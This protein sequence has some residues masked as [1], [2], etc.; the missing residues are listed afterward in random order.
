LEET[1]TSSST[2]PGKSRKAA[3][4][5][6][7][8]LYRL[9][10][11]RSI[12]LGGLFVVLL[13][14]GLLTDIELPFRPLWVMLVSVA[15]VNVFIFLRIRRKRPVTEKEFFI[16]LLLDIGFLS[17]ILYL[18]GGSSNPL[19][20]YYLI[21]LIISAAV[22]R[23]R[24][25][26]SIAILTVICYTLLFF[27]SV[28]QALFAHS[29]HGAMP[30]A[31]LVG[32]WV[33]FVFSA[34][35]I[36]WFVVRIAAT[37]REQEVAIARVREEGMRNEQ[38]VSV[39]G[40]AAGTAH[41][42]R[43]PLATMTVLAGEMK[44][45]HPELSEDL[46]LMEQQLGRCDEILRE[47]VSASTDSTARKSAA[48]A[49]L[50]GEI[51]EK[52]RIVRPEEPL[53]VTMSQAAGKVLLEYDLSLHHA[54]LNFLHN[55]ADASPGE[56]RLSTDIHDGTVL[57]EIEDRGPGIPPQIEDE[58]GRQYISR[59]EGGLGLGVLISSA[60]IERMQGRVALLNRAGGGARLEIRLP[61]KLKT[62][63]EPHA[64]DA[65]AAK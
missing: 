60:S 32:M 35:L 34:I 36:S 24:Y 52:W 8:N 14:A 33:N 58:L 54:L 38:I 26:W 51:Q 2:R 49:D 28:P 57:I 13:W 11:I 41:E 10:L 44:D 5:T 37:M 53:E 3:R 27:F 21:P 40:I 1:S 19:V 55:A 63:A 12:L 48:L 59:K 23:P 62:G 65:A 61:L 29:G 7:L 4:P 47:L 25:T 45:E 6:G 31:H 42:L 22:L 17:V 18:T 50:I 64:N 20:S 43:T 46:N 56:V 9:W 30:G 39:A 16:N 15:L